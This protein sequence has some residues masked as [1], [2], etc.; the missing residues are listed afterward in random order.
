MISREQRK[1]LADMQEAINSI[2]EHLDGKRD[3]QEYLDNKT[4]RR[5]VEREL[6]IIGEAVSLLLKDDPEFPLSL[7][8]QMKGMRNRILH[9]YD[10]VDDTIVWK[11]VV[12]DLP[13][14]LAEINSLLRS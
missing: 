12:I 14:L 3:F 4:K 10:A 6:G 2:D 5:A 11:T 1:L 13:V 7:A 9:A 8:N